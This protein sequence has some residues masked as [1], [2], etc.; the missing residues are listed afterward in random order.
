[1]LSAL[2]ANQRHKKCRKIKRWT[3]DRHLAKRTRVPE[4]D[5]W[6]SYRR[7]SQ[8]GLGD[9]VNRGQKKRACGTNTLVIFKKTAPQ[10][11]NR[12]SWE[13]RPQ[14]WTPRCFQQQ[15]R[16]SAPKEQSVWWQHAD[17]HWALDDRHITHVFLNTTCPF[18]LNPKINPNSVPEQITSYS[19]WV[20][21]E[22]PQFWQKNFSQ[23]LDY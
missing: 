7:R 21:A 1:M 4:N 10:Q 3:T 15:V 5:K 11:P 9:T 13:P 17:E 2:R 18:L 20:V 23:N 22:K 19:Q 14:W 6:V 8:Y 16:C 12:E